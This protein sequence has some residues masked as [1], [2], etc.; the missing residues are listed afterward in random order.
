MILVLVDSKYDGTSLLAASAPLVERTWGWEIRNEWLLV[1]QWGQ[2]GSGRTGLECTPPFVSGQSLY[3]K[4][5]FKVQIFSNPRDLL[6]VSFLAS[7]VS[8]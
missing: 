3:S 2:V 1:R 5:L 8:I 7:P 4:A 6:D